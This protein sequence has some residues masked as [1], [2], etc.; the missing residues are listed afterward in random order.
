MK[1]IFGALSLAVVLMLVVPFSA[2][3]TDTDVEHVVSVDLDIMDVAVV[4]VI[5]QVFADLDTVVTDCKEQLTEFEAD[6]ASQEII[7]PDIATLLHKFKY[8][9]HSNIFLPI[10]VGLVGAQTYNI[11]LDFSVTHLPIEVGRSNE[12]KEYEVPEIIKQISLGIKK[13]TVFSC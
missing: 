7:L 2:Q 4:V 8:S 13:F 3:S 10:E 6:V 12:N 9:D 5:D 11:N 1:K